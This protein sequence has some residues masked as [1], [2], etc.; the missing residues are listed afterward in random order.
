MWPRWLVPNCSSKPSAVR[1]RGGAITPALLISRSIS[2]SQAAANSRTDS[3]LARSSSRTSVS[4]AIVAA[5][6]PPL[7]RPRTA[8][9]TRALEPPF[10][11]RADKTHGARGLAAKPRRELPPEMG[12]SQGA[13]PPHFA[14]RPALLDGLAESGFARLGS[15][16]RAAAESAGED[17]EARLR[18]TS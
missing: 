17:Y 4:P 6:A 11:G 15:Q 14:D 5:A 13:P 8:S 12:A 9:T 1:G 16:L 2:P 18:T 10:L 7:S 3:T